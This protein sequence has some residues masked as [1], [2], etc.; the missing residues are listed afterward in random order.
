MAAL[1]QQA[2]LIFLTGTVDF[3]S[4]CLFLGTAVSERPF[5]MDKIEHCYHFCCTGEN[6]IRACVD[7]MLV[8][9]CA[10]ILRT[11]LWGAVLIGGKSS[12]MGSPKHLLTD[13]TGRTWLENTI[14][15]LK[16]YVENI[17]IS[18]TGDV[19]RSIT[20]YQRVTDLAGVSGPIAGIGALFREQPLHSWLV[21]ACDMPDVSTESIKWLLQQR[22][23]GRAGVIPRSSGGRSQPLFAWYNYRSVP[24]ITDM[25]KK[26]E[27]RVSRL[28]E[29]ETMYQLE[30]PEALRGAW[31]NVNCPAQLNLKS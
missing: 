11:P 14:D 4:A 31:R 27:M 9:L 21:L 2:D 3:E 23:P 26:G 16:P 1:L 24:L 22:K 19:P 28:G 20:R 17:V 18:G 15:C 10:C 7:H 30:I 25:I 13:F 8:W 6:D 5:G 29:Y 12:R